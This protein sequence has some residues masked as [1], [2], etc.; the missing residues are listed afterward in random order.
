MEYDKRI[1]FVVNFTYAAFIVILVYVI[2]KYV[3]GLIAPFLF[4]FIIAYLLR[5]PSRFLSDKLKISYKLTAILLVLLFYCTIGV[6]I[7]LLAI[8]LFSSI[9][10]L[11]YNLPLVFGTHIEPFLALL[12]EEIQRSVSRM[13]P[14][15][16][17]A[18]NEFYADF[19]QSIGQFI[20]NSSMKA[21]NVI[22][23]YATSLPGMFIRLLL[24]IISTFFIAADYDKLTSFIL[25]Q[26]SGKSKELII[27]IKEY[28]VGT[29][30]V[31]FRS[32]ALIMSITFVE[33][34]IGLTLLGISK[35]VLIA[36]FIAIFDILPV[37]G[38]GGIMVP[39]AFITL[40]RGKYSLALGLLIVYLI[41][42]VVRNIIEP[43]IVG[44]QIGLHP[45]V[46]LIS[47]FI[48]AHLFGIIGLFGFP[49][50]LSLLRHLND[51]GAIKLFK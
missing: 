21:V 19:T 6:G 17:S 15:L 34:S 39:W 5:K 49:I 47:L 37:L 11:I 29:L 9:K 4:A 42:T 51:T 23:D 32:Y 33:L 10:E 45:V 3:L 20:S 44:S 2:L 35:S 38:T 18:L 30:F 31:C 43:K 26:F 8:K 40:L 36:L 13:D 7:S 24:M 1:K 41:V 28:I 48:G 22:S 25:R 46:T 50:T 27:R 16:L 12:F 14:A